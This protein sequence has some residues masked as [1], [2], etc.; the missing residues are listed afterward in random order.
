M[1]VDGLLSVDT[2]QRRRSDDQRIKALYQCV[3]VG[4]H[5]VIANDICGIGI[6]LCGNVLLP[7]GNGMVH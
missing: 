3:S 1:N 2:V 7:W 6:Y 5:I 4:V